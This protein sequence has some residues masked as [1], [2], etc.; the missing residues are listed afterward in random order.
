[1]GRRTLIASLTTVTTDSDFV[2]CAMLTSVCRATVPP[3]L[4]FTDMC[5]HALPTTVVLRATAQR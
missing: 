4:W 5:P 2:F 1:M 3:V